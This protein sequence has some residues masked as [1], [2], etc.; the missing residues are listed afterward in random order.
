MVGTCKIGNDD[1]SVVGED[2]K[3]HNMENIRVVDPSV[4]P[5]CLSSPN[6]TA[7]SLMMAEIISEK[8]LRDY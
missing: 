3:V 4:I 2:L 7:T 8:I 1:M 6:N 5:N